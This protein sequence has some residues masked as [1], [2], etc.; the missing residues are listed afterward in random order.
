MGLIQG[1]VDRMA[2]KK[3]QRVHEAEQSKS[4]F[5]KLNVKISKFL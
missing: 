3:G 1:A 2:F 4:V 5:F